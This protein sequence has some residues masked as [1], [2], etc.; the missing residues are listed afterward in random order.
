MRHI[1]AYLV[2]SGCV[3]LILVSNS[4]RLLLSVDRASRQRFG[5]RQ[6]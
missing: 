6:F 3:S 4:K 2:I 1:R 5:K